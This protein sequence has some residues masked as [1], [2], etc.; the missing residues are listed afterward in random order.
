MAELNDS[1]Q[2]GLHASVPTIMEETFMQ[3]QCLALSGVASVDNEI[4]FIAR[5][6]HRYNI[7]TSSGVKYSPIHYATDYL[8]DINDW[9]L[10]VCHDLARG[11]SPSSLHKKNIIIRKI[12]GI[13][14]TY[15]W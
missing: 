4:A 9:S 3:R 2:A 11:R 10:Q 7:R 12:A 6:I 5:E 8:R 1:S 13:I 14:K 15:L